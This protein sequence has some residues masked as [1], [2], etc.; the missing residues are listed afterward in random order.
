M[1]KAVINGDI[2]VTTVL[3]REL[4]QAFQ[5]EFPKSLHQV[6][7]APD[8]ALHG[9]E[10]NSEV[11]AFEGKR[12]EDVGPD[13]LQEC[14]DAPSFLNP[15]AFHYFFPAFIKQSQADVDR[16]SLLVGSIIGMLA[17]AG[18]RWPESL[19]AAEAEILR[20]NPELAETVESIHKNELSAWRQER[21]ELFTHQQWALI[22][23]WLNWI[24]Q[25]E[26]W[27]M[28]RDVL[29]QAIKNAESWQSKLL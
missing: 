8:E 7:R 13:L 6:G 23:K 4:H 1:Q 22:L 16:T 24:N 29:R 3:E 27:E 12:W 21:W 15:R 20:E 5:R 18:F 28:D 14:F 2:T 11:K 19:K 26:R 25:D 17:D 10:I 9:F